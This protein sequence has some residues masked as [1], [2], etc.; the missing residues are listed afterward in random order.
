[1]AGKAPDP[2][3]F[4][5]VKGGPLRSKIFQDATL[6]AAAATMTLDRYG[7]LFADQLDEV[8]DALDAARGASTQAAVARALPETKSASIPSAEK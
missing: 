6:T 7:Q 2:L 4:T 5:G 8:A 3:V 1:M